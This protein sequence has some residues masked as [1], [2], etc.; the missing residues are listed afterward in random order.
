MSIEMIFTD[1][2][3][4][5]LTN[6]WDREARKKAV[7]RFQLDLH[8]FEGRHKEVVEDLESGVLTLDGYLRH[9][10]FFAER[11]FGIHDFQEFM[12]NCSQP[13][14]NMLHLLKEAKSALGCRAAALSNEGKEL[15]HYRI[16]KFHLKEVLD[17]FIVSG[18]VGFAKP[19]ERIYKLAINI[20]QT[21]PRHIVYIDDR[22]HL[23]EAGKRMG[24]QTILHHS[25]EETRAALESMTGGKISLHAG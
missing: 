8:E 12:F 17:F 18:F 19:D 14:K 3:G 13:Y 16:E 11:N 21:L 15:G 23:I 6:G 22:P 9:V 24:L 25:V 10:V 4:V 7:E 5:I 20:S 1:I 2:G